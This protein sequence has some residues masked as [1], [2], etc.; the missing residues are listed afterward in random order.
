MNENIIERKKTIILNYDLL[1]LP[2]DLSNSIRTAVS[3][4]C[5]VP[6]DAVFATCTHTHTGP[7]LSEIK[8]ESD[9][10]NEMIRDYNKNLVLISR[11]CAKFAFDDL[12]DA[13][14]YVAEGEAK[15]IS[16]V[17]RFR[18]KDG[19]VQTNPGADNPNIDHCLDEASEVLKLIEIINY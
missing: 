1:D 6:F 11:D 16:F 4:Y 14:F 8:T 10:I 2:T 17:R 3:E 13:E 18:M 15:N 7:Q 9:E 19:S 12:Q 5:D